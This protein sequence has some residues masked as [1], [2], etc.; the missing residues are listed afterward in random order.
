MAFKNRA[1]GV[2]LML[3]ALA[4]CPVNGYVYYV[5]PDVADCGAHE[6]C[7]TLNYYANSTGLRL[8]DS[9][10]YFMPGTHPLRQSWVISNASNLSLIPA[11]Y[12]AMGEQVV[13]NCS[14]IS[15]RGITVTN[16][17]EIVLRAM[18][19]V[20][21]QQFVDGN[22]SS[23][24]AALLFNST[25]GI[26]LSN[27]SVAFTLG[28]CLS[29]TNCADFSIDQA[30]F[31]NAVDGVDLF[32]NCSGKLTSIA[33][34]ENFIGIQL[35]SNDLPDTFITVHLD[36]IVSSTNFVAGLGVS[37]PANV[38]LRNSE[39]RQLGGLY[40]ET[41]SRTSTYSID[42]QNCT[43]MD[44]RKGIDI[45]VLEV[46]SLE[47]NVV[48]CYFSSPSNLAGFPQISVDAGSLIQ[49]GAHEVVVLIKNVTM[50]NFNA[51]LPQTATSVPPLVYLSSLQQIV[52]SDVN[53]RNNTHGGLKLDNSIA[54]FKA[55]NSFINNS[56]VNGGGIALY[57]NTYILID[58]NSTLEIIDNTAEKFG[59]GM[60]ILQESTTRQFCIFQLGNP[61]PRIIFQGNKAGYTGSDL[62]GGNL[63][64]CVQVNSLISIPPAKLGLLINTS[65]CHQTEVSSDAMNL[66]FCDG[67]CIDTM[68]T[69]KMVSAYPGVQ[70]NVSVAALGQFGGLTQAFAAITYDE[71]FYHD[72]TDESDFINLTCTNITLDIRVK[73]TNTV[74]TIN[75]TASDL[76]SLSPV[77]NPIT[78]V[79][80]ILPCPAGFNLSNTNQTCVCADSIDKYAQ[81]DITSQT[82][83]RYGNSW[84]SPTNES[85]MI[86][87]PCPYDY[88]NNGAFPVNS[89]NDQC[90]YNRTGTLCGDCIQGYSL[91][92]GSNQCLN[93][94]NQLWKVPTI[95]IGSAIAGILLVISLITLNLTISVGTINGLLFFVNVVNI[96]D[97]ILFQDNQCPA[98]QYFIA[99]LNLDLGIPTCFL[100]GMGACEKVGLQ[101]VFPLYLF[102]LVLLIVSVCRCGQWPGFRSI[103]LM[104]RLSDKTALLMGSKP[105]PVLATLLLFS[106][107]KLVRTII[108]IY[109]KA[110]VQVFESNGSISVYNIS[111][112]WYV[113]GNMNYLSGCHRVLFGVSTAIVVPLIVLFTVFLLLFPLMEQHLARLRFWAPFHLRLKP[114]YD[115]YGGPYKDHYRSWSGLLLLVRC[116]LVLVVTV[117]ND[118]SVTLSILTWVCL[119]LVP[120]VALLQVYK[121]F[122]LNVLEIAYLSCILAMVFFTS[123]PYG[124]QLYL[125]LAIQACL[126]VLIVL[127]HVGQRLK[128]ARCPTSVRRK[129]VHIQSDSVV[130]EQVDA[131]TEDEDDGKEKV[132]IVSRTQLKF[133]ELREPM[134]EEQSDT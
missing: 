30:L 2:I 31:S 80:D 127:L 47:L 14:G 26:T 37:S 105:I 34:F 50:E 96:Y 110:N 101:F 78:V 61:A 109:R 99:W 102:V 42:V 49:D 79:V 63:Y 74:G 59:G 115:A 3:A 13:V 113:N 72:Q 16:S 4:L 10:F 83:S 18:Q 53:I 39:F 62:Y 36:Q 45:L 98:L 27:F 116:L 106:Y 111:S 132:P 104:V 17:R 107:T 70:L 19:I 41:D 35:S 93:C 40:M 88:C 124:I 23:L 118:S 95:L 73:R 56:A 24:S 43:F 1:I 90:A 86:F 28:S 6:P 94:D 87:D 51:P 119:I 84:V 71:V 68:Q 112:K 11:P 44:S 121:S 12:S 64:S 9:V 7:N 103:P 100:D 20:H 128:S 5:A 48:S 15:G 8:T 69:T 25:T 38:T 60:F 52:I 21:C 54:V 77:E 133:D 58:V 75:L 89:P 125:V 85:I 46:R 76:Y 117:S 114:W 120:L 81:C 91:S 130:E 55:T 92:L 131:I 126:F 123:T 82:I 134:L 57:G 108:L 97:S 122:L 65:M 129:Y 67:D 33:T 32:E 22:E 29:M 66:T